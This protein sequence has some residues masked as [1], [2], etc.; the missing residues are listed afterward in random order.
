M[1]RRAVLRTVAALLGAATLD[2]QS[3]VLG[4]QAGGPSH[5]RPTDPVA[6]SARSTGPTARRVEWPRIVIK[7][8]YTRDAA[9]G[10]LKG[11][12]QL[13]GKP[14]CQSLFSEFQ[15]ARGRPLTE[16][17]RE[18]SVTPQSYLELV[19]FFD[20][21]QSGACKRDGVLAFTEPGSR[22]IHLCG[23]YF[24]RASRRD[25]REVQ[26]TI[27]HEVLHSLG[28]GENPPAPGYITY[29]VRQLCS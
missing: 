6:S 3:T 11:A 22:V 24:E 28:L 4:V 8:V 25:A 9:K 12:H 1:L 21:E 13:L 20:G 17:L 15:D 27:I 29:R 5:R 18:L 26:A 10:A 23:R 16:K 2:G 14:V 19:Y 7:D